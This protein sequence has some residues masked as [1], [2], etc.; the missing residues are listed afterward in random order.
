MIKITS[1][2]AK[3]EGERNFFCKGCKKDLIFFKKS[4]N[5]VPLLCA[6]ALPSAS[7][8]AGYGLLGLNKKEVQNHGKM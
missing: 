7:D 2:S 3:K 8:Y 4:A 6:E 1:V 5:I